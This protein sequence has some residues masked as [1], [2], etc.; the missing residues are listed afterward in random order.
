MSLPPLVRGAVLVG[1][2]A[3][4]SRGAEVD[5]QPPAPKLVA[6]PVGSAQGTGGSGTSAC[7]PGTLPDARVCI[8]V[9]AREPASQPRDLEAKDQVPKRP[10]R[11]PSYLAYQLP[12][13]LLDQRIRPSDPLEAGETRL[14]T[15]GFELNAMPGAK[16][17][18]PALEA[19]QGNAE[20]VHAGTLLGPTIVTRHRTRFGD[21]ERVYLLILGHLER[22]AEGLTPGRKLE[23]G[24][25]VGSIGEG[26]L[27]GP[28]LHLEVRQSRQGVDANTLR[29]EDLLDPSK[30][31]AT[32]PR[33]V[34]AL[35]PP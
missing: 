12:V 13:A 31:I 35:K 33:N 16:V 18:L 34:L 4:L 17:F 11:P 22:L 10:E 1:L 19:Q 9:P 6:I 24:T 8:P 29:P 20:I 7:P 32:D 21:S 23:P 2:L 28:V 14:R 26:G 15:G 3:A 30:T 27:T 25:P 5:A